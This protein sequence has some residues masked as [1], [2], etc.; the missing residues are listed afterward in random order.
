VSPETVSTSPRTILHG[1][2]THHPNTL[3][4]DRSEGSQL[5]PR[6][7]LGAPGRRCPSALAEPGDGLS[8][9]PSKTSLGTSR[10]AVA[11][12]L[13]RSP[14]TSRR[15]S[16]RPTPRGLSRDAQ[17]GPSPASQEARHTTSICPRS[18][19]RECLRSDP[20]EPLNALR[21]HPPRSPRQPARHGRPAPCR[22]RL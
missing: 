13:R 5:T 20:R 6:Q 4:H 17:P 22:L 18:G 3:R 14:R 8:Q 21:Q 2:P 16:E 12:P 10:Q 7:P 9:R 15:A 11:R 1:A 19:C